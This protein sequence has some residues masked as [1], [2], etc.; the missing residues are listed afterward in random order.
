MSMQMLRRGRRVWTN[1]GGRW[2]SSAAATGARSGGMS[3]TAFQQLA[4]SVKDVRVAEHQLVAG[5]VVTT[6]MQ[7]ELR[8]RLTSVD[9]PVELPSPVG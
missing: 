6:M 7:I 3:A 9:E 2:Q 4:R 5:K 8:Y 1:F